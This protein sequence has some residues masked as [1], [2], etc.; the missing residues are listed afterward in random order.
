MIGGVGAG[1]EKESQRSGMAGTVRDGP[2]SEDYDGINYFS[3]KFSI[4]CIV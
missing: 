3:D 4:R 2:I 1:A